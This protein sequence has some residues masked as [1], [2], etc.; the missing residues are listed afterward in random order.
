MPSDRAVRATEP[1]LR[2]QKQ[3]LRTR[4]VALR[5]AL[6]AQARADASHAIAERI[7]ALPAFNTARTVLATLP[8]RSEWD[9]RPLIDAWLARGIGVALPRVDHEARML[10]LH[11]ID[12]PATQTVAGAM[13][14]PEP[15]AD[16][17]VVEPF[18][19]DCVLVPGV[20][21]DALGRRLGYG[22][23]YYDRLLPRL[24]SPAPR[25]VGAFDLQLVDEVP[26]AAHDQRVD[27]IV[28]ERRVLEI[29]GLR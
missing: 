12:D 13:G 29:E 9:T 2:A 26:A 14:V 10:V 22:G 17:P 16:L 3:A 21:F 19:V 11:A 25:I 24:P 8:F 7:A 1:V 20:A 4:I 23:G 18:A 6:S 27:R 15:R 5:D 28:T